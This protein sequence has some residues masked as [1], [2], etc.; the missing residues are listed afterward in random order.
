MAK[1]GVDVKKLITVPA[2]ITLGILR[3]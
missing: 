1:N 3:S 2:L